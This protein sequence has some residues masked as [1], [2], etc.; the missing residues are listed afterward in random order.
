MS[1]QIAI[2][3]FGPSGLAL[4]GMLEQQGISYVVYERSAEDTSRGGCLDIHRSS[5][6]DALKEAGCFE[7]FNKYAR[8]GN[9]TIHAVWDSKGNKL[10]TFGEGRDWPEVDR[11]QL[12][13]TL[14]R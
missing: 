14:C 10:F 3:G 6:L 1:P 7:E 8:H 9:A 5:G 12:K 11:A 13:Q 2:V 4:V